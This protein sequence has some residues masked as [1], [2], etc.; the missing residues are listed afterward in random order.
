MPHPSRT[1]GLIALLISPM[2]AMPL[3]SLS[4]QDKG[5]AID[6]RSLRAGIAHDLLNEQEDAFAPVIEHVWISN[7]GDQIARDPESPRARALAD[8]LVKSIAYD[9]VSETLSWPIKGFSDILPAE[10][11][12][13]SLWGIFGRYFIA[14]QF[15]TE[16]AHQFDTEFVR[17]L[18]ANFVGTFAENG[19]VVFDP[20]LPPRG[21][22]M[23]PRRLLD[24]TGYYGTR[25]FVYSPENC[26]QLA[27]KCYELG[28]YQDAIV[29]LT[30]ALAQQKMAK[31]YYVRGTIELSLGRAEAA[32][33]SARGYIETSRTPAN[34]TPTLIYERVNG[35]SA[36]QFR[37]LAAALARL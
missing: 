35:P 28:F 7:G 26:F 37:D 15:D 11:A 31:Y 6:L 20:L 10:F 23:P 29:L 27:V 2:V 34:N 14:H 4:A 36:I 24:S 13:S 33:V 5:R 3:A 1:I 32:K 8:S 9:P 25:L 12:P 19:P 18:E 30:H 22:T 21:L 16:I 17:R